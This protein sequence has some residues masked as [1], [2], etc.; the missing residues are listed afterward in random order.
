DVYKKL[1]SLYNQNIA[2]DARAVDDQGIDY[3]MVKMDE[4]RK[5]AKQVTIKGNK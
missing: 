2:D 1:M 5:I 4:M 3:Y